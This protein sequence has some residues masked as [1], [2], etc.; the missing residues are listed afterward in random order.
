[1][2]PVCGGENRPGIDLRSPEGRTDMSRRQGTGG[3]RTGAPLTRDDVV[4]AALALVDEVG[5]RGFTMRA[6]ATRLGTYPA[7]L[8]WHAG[9]RN[10]ILAKVFQRAL[11]EMDVPDA[12]AMGWDGWLAAV[13]REYRR[14]QHRHPN[15]ATLALYPIVTSADLVEAILATLI[16]A[17]FHGPGLADAFNTFV[18]SVTGWVAVELSMATG[19]PDQQWNTDLESQVRSAVSSNHPTIAACADYVIDEVFTLRWHG[20]SDKPMDRSFDAALQA[21]IQGLR[22]MLSAED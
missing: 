10:E 14:V 2:A 1:M 15:T 20:G 17:G 4:V 18:G 7:T 9:S 5:I 3:R 12:R 6:L 13:A 16:G 11:A 8:Y 22:A 19:E 21:W